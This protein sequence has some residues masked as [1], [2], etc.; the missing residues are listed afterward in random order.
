M[1]IDSAT[2]AVPV[3]QNDAQRTLLHAVWDLLI[4]TSAWPSTQA[5][6]RLLDRSHDIDLYAVADRLP[7]GLV[8]PGHLRSWQPD[9]PV[10]LTVAGIAACRGSDQHLN[11]FVDCLRLAADLEREWDG[12][13]TEYG[14]PGLTRAVVLESSVRLPASG[15]DDFVTQLG[16]I[17]AAEQWGWSSHG[18]S[19][20]GEKRWW[21]GVGRDVRRWRDLSSISD[22][23]TRTRPVASQSA[24]LGSNE[25][26]AGLGSN[27][28][29]HVVALQGQPDPSQVFV[30]HGRND[31]A[32]KQLFTF[33]RSIGLRPIEWSRAVSLAG[34]GSP[35]IGDVLSAAFGAAQA[36]VVLET[37][38]DVA[39]LHP[40]LGDGPEDPE[41]R[42]QLQARPNVLFEAGMAMGWDQKR[43]VLATLGRV[44]SFSDIHGRHVVRLDNTPGKRQDLAQRLKVAG[45]SVDLEGRDWLDAGDFSVPALSVSSTKQSPAPSVIKGEDESADDDDFTFSGVVA[46]GGN[47]MGEARNN[48]QSTYTAFLTATFY[49][50]SG[51]IVATSDTVVN[52]VKP[53]RSKTFT[54]LGVPSH[55]DHRV[56]VSL[57][58]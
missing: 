5:L 34:E 58:T 40:D 1:A 17:L 10:K 24:D 2:A 41:G 48:S 16:H 4:Q 36:V 54:F 13:S 25:E 9:D 19:D 46:R 31:F 44:K 14:G 38:D 29:E 39:Y 55:D 22:Y 50:E 53:G 27:E 30:I 20:A 43:T 51:A 6:D 35:Y 56:E 11:A 32:R 47:L 8:I 37:P 42:P 49:D 12:D 33:L 57:L 15:R 18:T 28:K 45:C 52:A 26:L 23:L 3:P 7:M 21:F